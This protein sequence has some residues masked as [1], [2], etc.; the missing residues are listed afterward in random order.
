M[1]DIDQ[2][3]IRLIGE[4]RKLEGV[5]LVKEHTD[6]GLREAKDYVD[7]LE[8]QLN[9]NP[10]PKIEDETDF[11]LRLSELLQNG[12][13]IAAIKLTVE[14]Q[15]L[16]LK[17]AKDFVDYYELTL[18]SSEDVNLTQSEPLSLENEEFIQ[19]VYSLLYKNKKLEAIKLVKESMEN[20]S[21]LEAKTWVELLESKMG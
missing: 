9:Q 4:H 17:D 12:Q 18:E 14:Y 21:L 7:A 2:E 3:V 8:A 1:L 19:K 11:K 10:L 20:L 5:K 6:W 15:K 16:G 13:K